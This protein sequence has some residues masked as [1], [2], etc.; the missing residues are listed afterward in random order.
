MAVLKMNYPPEVA[1]YLGIYIPRATFVVAFCL[2]RPLLAKGASS[3]EG[4]YTRR[5]NNPKLLTQEPCREAKKSLKKQ[6]IV[7]DMRN[8]DVKYKASPSNLAIGLNGPLT[9]S[10]HD[11]KYHNSA[12]C[13]ECQIQQMP[14]PC[15]ANGLIK[16]IPTRQ[17]PTTYAA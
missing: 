9:N 16:M 11:K 2:Y 3:P 13:N 4:G 8:S 1:D 10:R 14:W 17:C 15:K 5:G 7:I 6:N 12:L